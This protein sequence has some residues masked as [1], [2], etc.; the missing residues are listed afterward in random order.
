MPYAEA[1]RCCRLVAQG[2]RP[3]VRADS[4]LSP[5]LASILGGP[6]PLRAVQL[7]ADD[8]ERVLSDRFLHGCADMG[9]FMT[10]DRLRLLEYVCDRLLWSRSNRDVACAADVD[11]MLALMESV[12]RLLEEVSDDMGPRG[13]EEYA[14]VADW[15]AGAVGFADRLRSLV[16][17]PESWWCGDAHVGTE[18]AMLSEA[19][20]SCCR[21]HELVRSC[22]LPA[23]A[24]L[25]DAP[26]PLGLAV[27]LPSGAVLPAGAEAPVS[28]VVWG[29]VD[30]ECDG[31]LEAVRA[32]DASSVT[33]WMSKGSIADRRLGDLSQTLSERAADRLRYP[34]MLCHCWPA[35]GPITETRRSLAQSFQ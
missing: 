3:S 11:G 1:F 20:R 10:V 24:R 2:R 26:Q 15:L 5:E 7:M 16:T 21:F 8:L 12:R 13:C 27:E 31:L 28:A 35:T 17:S 33:R 30:L 9:R 34:S 23:G 4:A 25:L 32:G 29:M 22:C 18:P 6:R 19:P 14:A